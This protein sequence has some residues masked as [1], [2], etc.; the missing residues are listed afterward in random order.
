MKRI[1]FLMLAAIASVLAQAQMPDAAKWR[2]SA[3]VTSD[4][5][6]EI[7]MA[8]TINPG[9]HVYAPG[10]PKGGPVAMIFDF[11]ASAGIELVGEP[12]PSVVPEVTDDPVFGMKVKFWSKTV[13]FIQRFKIVDR[14]IAKIDGFVR[15]QGCNDKTCTPPKK[16]KINP[17]IK[18]SD[19]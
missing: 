1:F 9:W 14:K 12:V 19:K 15:F 3:S 13:N 7:F 10:I 11:S 8:M 17:E 5:N 2:S 4:G 18:Y 6:G 16:V